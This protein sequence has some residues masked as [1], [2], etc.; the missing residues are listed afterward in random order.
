MLL[1]ISHLALA[2]VPSPA[3]GDDMFGWAITTIQWIVEQFQAKN[4]MPA[5]GAIVMLAVFFIKKFFGDKISNARLTLLSAILGVLSS[6]AVSMMG[7]AMDASKMDIF[8]ALSNGLMVGAAASGFWGL[9][10]KHLLSKKEPAP[11]EIPPAPPE[12]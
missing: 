10:G 9:L 11:S 1:T 3:P 8:S 2:V 6:V 4:Y 12:V 5:V 7:V